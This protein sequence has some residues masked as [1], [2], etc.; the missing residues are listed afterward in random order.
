VLVILEASE[1]LAVVM[2]EFK[3]SILPA[4]EELVVTAVV[5]TVLIVAA[6]EELFVFI[7]LCNP[8]ILRAAEE[9]FVVTV[10]CRVVIVDAKDELL[11]V[12]AEE[13]VSNFTA[14]EELLFTTVWL[15]D[16][17]D[18]ASEELFVF[19]VLLR[20]LSVNASEELFVV[21]VALTFDIED[22][23][24]ALEFCTF[25]DIVSTLAANEELAFTTVKFVVVIDAA[26][27]ELLVLML[28]CNP[29]ILRAADELFVVTVFE[30]CVNEDWRDDDTLVNEELSTTNWVASEALVLANAVLISVTDAANDALSIDPV[31]SAAAEMMS[32]LPARDDDASTN[33]VFTVLIV[34]AK[35]ALF[36]FIVLT[37]LS[38]LCAADE[39]LVVTAPSTVVIL[40]ASDELVVF[41][42][43]WIVSILTAAEELTVAIVAWVVLMLEARE[44]L[45]ES[46][47]EFKESI[48]RAIE[49]LAS[50]VIARSEVMLLANDEL[51][52][53]NELSTL[54]I[55]AAKDEESVV[56]VAYMSWTDAAR[57][58]EFWVTLWLKLLR[59]DEND[60][61]F[62]TNAAAIEDDATFNDES[63]ESDTIAAEDDSAEMLEYALE[64]F[65][66]IDWDIV[67]MEEETDWRALAKE[68]EV[69]SIELA[70]TCKLLDT[71][72]TP[73][74]IEFANEADTDEILPSRDIVAEFKLSC[75][76]VTEAAA[77]AEFWF[78]TLYTASKLCDIDEVDIPAIWAYTFAIFSV[79]LEARDE[80]VD[81]ILWFRLYTLEDS[82][83]KL[84]ET[85]SAN[86]EENTFILC[87][88]EA[89][90][91]FILSI[92]EPIVAANEAE[93]F[94]TES[95]ICDRLW[96]IVLTDWL[97]TAIRSV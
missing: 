33:V 53:C 49:E 54:C 92:T 59:L 52:V 26:I 63:M 87:A 41:I 65:W 42:E 22:A 2:L 37:I 71:E 51:A 11:V 97:F 40:E 83:D 39:L 90:L 5:F 9:L 34:A 43:L 25:E 95:T 15:T 28:L 73:K 67:N 20:L 27:E 68:A 36:V 74:L 84:V 62:C 78:I 45:L 24:E 66:S 31:P 32:I 12:T 16:P 19:R 21:T 29:S 60:A 75:I 61:E 3:E 14:I 56:T 76:V 35:E 86:E 47:L 64:M 58:D 17:I 44:E 79:K 81:V 38:I 93:L 50:V 82:A 72:F 8:S 55:L 70:T 80:D 96:E 57:E 94:D 4:N 6:K 46:T 69:E 13:M 91:L 18:A 30:S 1:E 23:N 88:N 77:D 85:D 89:E 48:V 7:L 10:P